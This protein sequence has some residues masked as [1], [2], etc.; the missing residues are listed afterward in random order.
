MA[1]LAFEPQETRT[2]ASEALLVAR[3]LW[4][5]CG[6]KYALLWLAQ[7]TVCR[8][9]SL[10]VLHICVQA[11]ESGAEEP[12]PP[13][14][15]LRV[16]TIDELARGAP[17]DPTFPDW[18]VLQEYLA[19]GDLMIAAFHDGQIVSYGWCSAGQAAI[20]D[21]LT[22]GFG[23][24]F[25]YGH[26]AYTTPRHRGKGLHAAIIRYS[27]RVA[28][29]RGQAVVAYVDANNYKS[30]TSESRVGPLH[31]GIVV[32]SQRRGRLRYWASPLCRKVGLSL[33]AA[34]SVR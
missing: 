33:R 17:D 9:L 7:G 1:T 11:D 25:L 14:Y 20:A 34:P 19:G 6:L 4:K 2:G 29:Q 8:A 18:P 31:S 5:R 28:T 24:R 21:D 13:G 32:I 15:E 22:I 12:L 10:R 30:L 16:A 3:N 26:R 27:R 23:P